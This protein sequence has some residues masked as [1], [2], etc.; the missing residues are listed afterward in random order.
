MRTSEGS[1]CRLRTVFAADD[2]ISRAR[3]FDLEVEGGDTNESQNV[4][5]TNQ[6][7]LQIDQKMSCD[8]AAVS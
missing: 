2:P 3:Y 4:A 8:H 6:G 1:R 5:Y 7:R